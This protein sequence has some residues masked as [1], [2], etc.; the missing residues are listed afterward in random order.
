MDKWI[1]W[2]SKPYTGNSFTYLL[3]GAVST[4][5]C[6]LLHPQTFCISITKFWNK[7]IIFI[8]FCWTFDLSNKQKAHYRGHRFEWHWIHNHV[9][10]TSGKVETGFPMV[11]GMP[12]LLNI[13][14]PYTVGKLL[15]WLRIWKYSIHGATLPSAFVH[16][17][18][19]LDI[20]FMQYVP[21]TWSK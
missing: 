3:L 1:V 9:P 17:I 18:N 2:R 12:M 13:G 14:M 4:V 16:S 10:L 11:H 15:V 19:V 8:R 21:G 20:H 6:C 5:G 7:K